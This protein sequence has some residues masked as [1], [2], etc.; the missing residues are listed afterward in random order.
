MAAPQDR[1]I[2]AEKRMLQTSAAN[3]RLIMA[4]LG[5]VAIIAAFETPLYGILMW[6]TEMYRRGSIEKDW[7]KCLVY[8]GNF[9]EH[10]INS[11][12]ALQLVGALATS[13]FQALLCA[14][15]AIVLVQRASIRIDWVSSAIANSLFLGLNIL[16]PNLNPSFVTPAAIQSSLVILGS[17]VRPDMFDRIPK[18][19]HCQKAYNFAQLV[20]NVEWAAVVCTFCCMILAVRL[21]V[22]RRLAIRA[23]RHARILMTSEHNQE[24]NTLQSHLLAPADLRRS[25]TGLF[26]NSECGSQTGPLQEKDEDEIDQQQRREEEGAP[27]DAAPSETFL[28][29]Q[30]VSVIPLRIAASGILV[31]LVLMVT[32]LIDVYALTR[33]A[34]VSQG[35]ANHLPET[36][37][38]ALATGTLGDL[39]GGGGS[40]GGGGGSL[41]LDGARKASALAMVKDKLE[42]GF[43]FF[44]SAK[45]GFSLSSLIFF[46]Y[47]LFLRGVAGDDLAP[48]RLCA[49]FAVTLLVYSVPMYAAH[50]HDVVMYDLWKVGKGSREICRTYLTGSG[51]GAEVF[52]YPQ[53][54]DVYA[55]CTTIRLHFWAVGFHVLGIA[56]LFV[57]CAAAF[58]LNPGVRLISPTPNV[59]NEYGSEVNV[60]Q[61]GPVVA[62]SGYAQSLLSGHDNAGFEADIHGP[63]LNRAI[64][65][66]RDPTLNGGVIPVSLAAHSEV[67]ASEAGT[68]R[69]RAGGPPSRILRRQASPPEPRLA[70]ADSQS[71]L[72]SFGGGGPVAGDES[73][74]KTH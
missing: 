17:Y 13:I 34:I 18:P 22:R 47:S 35:S 52:Y 54:H 64:S 31:G 11:N 68:V 19:N 38:D 1:L 37:T 7:W 27:G 25:T 14:L 55:V 45:S 62:P 23:L 2:A 60:E 28:S 33:M 72:N 39:V 5:F 40:F 29:A 4:L 67:A 63:P 3:L 58:V 26:V 20:V 46:V 9:V 70:R 32:Y 36:L 48:M 71:S 56:A 8:D 44:V 61:G 59:V 51:N 24:D 73:P 43:V 49:I 41:N 74:R 16:L 15:L 69:Y 42:A 66:L 53:G 50:V 6:I 21:A 65:Y 30:Y 57:V 12:D 10:Y